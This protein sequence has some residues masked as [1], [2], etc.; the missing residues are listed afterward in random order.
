M[1]S[2]FTTSLEGSDDG[3]RLSLDIFSLGESR[4]I[5]MIAVCF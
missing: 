3:G 1:T 5:K 4:T 2:V